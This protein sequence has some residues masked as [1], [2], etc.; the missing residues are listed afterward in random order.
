[1]HRAGPFGLTMLFRDDGGKW[2]G[3]AKTLIT[4]SSTGAYGIVPTAGGLPLEHDSRLCSRIQGPFGDIFTVI[5]GT[6]GGR[7]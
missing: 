2:Y 1:M 3:E 7:G 6:V 4:S 5:Y